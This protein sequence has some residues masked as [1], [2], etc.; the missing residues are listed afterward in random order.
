M[1]SLPSEAS[2]QETADIAVVCAILTIT[3]PEGT[4]LSTNVSFTLATG[5]GMLSDL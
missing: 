3:P 2:V 1:V 5:D 4:S